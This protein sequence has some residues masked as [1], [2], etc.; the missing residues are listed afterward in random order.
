MKR[1]LNLSLS[2]GPLQLLHCKP[3]I[4]VGLELDEY[5][6]L[7]Y[8]GERRLRTGGRKVELA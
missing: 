2:F 8:T 7:L 3:S 6:C 1:L 5:V 4:E